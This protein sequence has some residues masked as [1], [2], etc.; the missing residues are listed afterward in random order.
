MYFHIT[1]CV[2][3]GASGVEIARQISKTARLVTFSKIENLDEDPQERQQYESKFAKTVIFKD[4][5]ERFTSNGAV[6]KDGSH[7]NFTHV[8]YATGK[9]HD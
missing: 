2:K 4:I 6:F 3:G 1:I 8:I 7:W 5:V 9:L